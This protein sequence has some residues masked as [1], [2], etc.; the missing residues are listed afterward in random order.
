MTEASP[1]FVKGLFAQLVTAVGGNEAAGAYIGVCHQRVSQL[2]RVNCPDMP[3]ILQVVV[4]QQ[5]VGLPIVT[6][7]LSDLVAGVKARRDLE[8]ESREALHAMSDLDRAVL[9]GAPTRA[10]DDLL[11]K[12]QRELGDVAHARAANEEAA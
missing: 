9:T 1:A 12:A 3:T 11:A 8:K 7:A 6:D 4:L 5:A 10:I 2:K